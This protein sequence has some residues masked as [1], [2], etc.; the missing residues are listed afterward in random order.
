MLNAHEVAGFAN[1]R[2]TLRVSKPIDP[3]RR[4]YWLQVPFR[5]S[6]PIMTGMAFLHWLIS[7]SIFLVQLNV[8]DINGN[9]DPAQSISACGYS[10][11]TIVLALC[12]GSVLVL[13]LLALSAR[14]LGSGMP[15]IGPCSVAIAAA[16]DNQDEPNAAFLP[17]KYGVV[18]RVRTDEHGRQ[19]VGFSS[20]K[21]APLEDG[22]MYS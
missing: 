18:L 12:L 4:T 6:I 11:I 2:K 9:I 1:V 20:K 15:L 16:C 5:Y 17:L 13:V 14:K 7:R 22:V 3:Q 19:H 10:P 8:Y 21:V